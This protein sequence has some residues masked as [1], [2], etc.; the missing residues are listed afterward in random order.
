MAFTT[1]QSTSFQNAS[2]VTP[3]EL[4]TTTSLII[5]ML[6]ILWLAW[7][8]WGLFRLWVKGDIELADLTWG[9]LRGTVVVLMVTYFIR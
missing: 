1:G 2:G 4:L 9:I 6:I 3:N 7:L 8:A 5:G